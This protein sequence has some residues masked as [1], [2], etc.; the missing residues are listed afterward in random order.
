MFGIIVAGLRLNLPIQAW[1]LIGAIF[2]SQ[3]R[4]RA[5]GEIE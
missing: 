2:L 4:W 3:K 1:Q 5:L